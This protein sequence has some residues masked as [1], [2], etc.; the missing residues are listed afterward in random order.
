MKNL[1]DFLKSVET[2]VDPCLRYYRNYTIS[3]P[4]SFAK[5]NKTKQNKTKNKCLRKINEFEQSGR[6]EL[7]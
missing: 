4:S 2:V 5:K 3:L 7:A 6:F 1:T